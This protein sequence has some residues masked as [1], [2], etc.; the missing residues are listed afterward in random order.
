VFLGVKV[1]RVIAAAAAAGLLL[2]GFQNCD[3]VKFQSLA[4]KVRDLCVPNSAPELEPVLKFAWTADPAGPAPEW[5]YV[6]STPM[7]GDLDRDGIP[8]IV[9]S[10]FTRDPVL[11]GAPSG[12]NGRGV[13]RVIRGDNGAIKGSVLDAT[14]APNGVTSPLLIDLDGD[15]Y[16]EIVY[17]DT[18]ETSVIALNHDLSPRWK[19]TRPGTVYGVGYACMGGPAAADLDGDGRSEIIA[20]R[21]VLRENPSRQPEM[22][23]EGG[24][25]AACTSFAKNFDPARPN[26]M[27]VLMG[28]GLYAAD[29]TKLWTFAPAQK[30]GLLAASDIDPANPGLEIV[31][32]R[33]SMVSLVRAS[34]GV[35]LWER[36]VP[37]SQLCQGANGPYPG[38]GGPPTIADVDGDGALDIGV[39]TGR[40][41][42]VFKKNGDYLWYKETRDCSSSITGS[43]LFDFNGDGRN[44]VLYADELFARI[45]DGQTGNTL[46]ELPNPSGTLLENPIVA[47]ADGDGTS[48]LILATN[49]YMGASFY[50]DAGPRAAEVMNVPPGIRVY[51]ARSQSRWVPTRKVWNQYSYFVDNVTDELRPTSPAQARKWSGRETFRQN[52]LSRIVDFCVAN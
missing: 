38:S 29:G 35:V 18:A 47:D 14:W 44:E 51:Q 27:Q 28:D 34:D 7:V 45:Y 4:S 11:A 13:L 22:V 52:V 5:T 15:G 46:F 37:Q 50:N 36:S 8:E 10:S 21:L 30:S 39:A 20:G 25:G 49:N 26:T 48:E 12:Y 41:Y 40:F 6:M 9:F 33:Q 16:G 23:F 3:N 31:T 42:T 32:V 19:F 17:V 24:D 43:S 2:I 1:K